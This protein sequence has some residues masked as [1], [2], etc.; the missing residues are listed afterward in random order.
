MVCRIK[1]FETKLL[2]MPYLLTPEN[3]EHKD[4]HTLQGK[5]QMQLT[6]CMVTTIDLHT[7][8]ESPCAG[9]ITH[10]DIIIIKAFIKINLKKVFMILA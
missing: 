3:M 7:N 8:L 9:N 5:V 10:Y 6:T 1:P 2:H 4:E